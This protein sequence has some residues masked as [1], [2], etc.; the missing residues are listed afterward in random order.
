MDPR[1]P[2]D[3]RMTATVAAELQPLNPEIERALAANHARFLRFLE[4]RVGSRAAA[5]EILQSALVR[6]LEKGVPADDGEGAVNW[7][8]RVLRNALIDHHRSS[9]A[10]ERALEHVHREAPEGRADP[11]LRETVCACMHDLLPGLKPEYADIVRRVDLEERPVHEVAAE[12]GI[13]AN[14]AAVRLH[15]AR[16]ALRKQLQRMCGSCAAHGC[17]HCSCRGAGTAKPS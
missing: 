5:E 11:E 2:Y 16:G 3:R 6:A 13:T 7:L 14:N 10:E 15:R 1:V 12:T 17:L 9:G 8:Y 4:A